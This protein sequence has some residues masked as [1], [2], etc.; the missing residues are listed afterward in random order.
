LY[1]RVAIVVFNNTGQ[2]IGKKPK[3]KL[4]HRFVLR[5]GCHDCAQ[6]HELEND[7]RTKTNI[8]FLMFTS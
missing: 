8:F 4:F 2:N 5:S 1:H 6:E 3:I 7:K